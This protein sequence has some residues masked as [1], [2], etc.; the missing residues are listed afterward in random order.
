MR[1]LSKVWP[2]GLLLAGVLA[3]ATV[4]YAAPAGPG[5][6]GYGPRADG[7]PHGPMMGP[8]YGMPMGG[9]MGSGGM[10]GQ[11]QI[12]PGPRAY[13]MD[14]R[15]IE[16]MIPHHQDAIAMADLALGQA[17]HPEIKALAER[18]KQTQAAEIVQMRGWY[19]A[20]YGTDVPAG[21][22]SRTMP[23]MP[24]HDPA[25]LDGAVP[26]DQAFIREMI[27]HHQMAVMMSSHMAWA[28]EHPELKTLMESIASGQAAEIEQMRQ[29]YQDWYGGP[30]GV[31]R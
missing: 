1:Q 12:G 16:E 21:F 22:M 3:L 27:P 15:Y 9:M 30:V 5:G 4:T 29:W 26:F 23:G 19:L 24:G 7:V 18:I 31:G 8:G 20:W 2:V 17:E 11:G 6:P 25:V 14:R 13:E 28:V 10:M